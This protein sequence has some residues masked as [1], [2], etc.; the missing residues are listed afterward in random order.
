MIVR[1][2]P[3]VI[4]RHVAACH[5]SKR[6][7]ERWF[8]HTW[9]K[10]NSATQVRIPYCCNSWRCEVC[11]RHEAAVTFARIKEAAAPLDPSGWCFLVLTLDQLGYY[12]GNPW[13][14]I[15]DAYKNLGALTRAF[16]SRLGAIW[17]PES[18]LKMKGRGK[19]KRLVT[20]RRLGNRWVSTVEA[21]RSGWPH[22]NL[23]VWCPELAEHLRAEHAAR[24]DDPE[25]A[26]AVALA[27]DAWAR[28]EPIPAHL[29]ELARKATRIGGALGEVL[30][31]TRGVGWGRESTAEVPRDLE[32]VFGYLVKVAG[33]HEGSVGELAK[34]TQVPLCADARFRRL[35]SGK[36]FLP[37]RRCNPNITGC[38]VRRRRSYEG[39]WEILAINPPKDPE[40]LPNVAKARSAEFQLILEEEELLSKCRGKL[41]P[42]P[43]VRFTRL[44]K[45][46][47]HRET[48]AERWAAMMKEALAAAG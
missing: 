31:D 21:H 7:T 30:T 32:A 13:E 18:S 35:R 29:R 3:A 39:D 6:K 28:K 17:G 36:G 41:P 1:P 2:P 27:R 16:L 22:V 15:Q 25:I 24:L 19:K 9:N 11:R 12:G 45:L 8:V 46:E 5:H 10:A 44:G 26:N 23:L 42:M 48:T 4:P 40:Q 43:P 34:V 33:L 38:L 20:V 47:G 37:P 14:S